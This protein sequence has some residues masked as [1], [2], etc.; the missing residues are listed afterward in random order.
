MNS[1][2]ILFV[3]VGWILP[4][5]N[6]NIGEWDEVWRRRAEDA[7]NRTLQAYH[8]NPQ[9]VVDHLNVHVNR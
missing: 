1:R 4:V 2:F 5:L 3:V 8:P 6:A 9:N 7:W